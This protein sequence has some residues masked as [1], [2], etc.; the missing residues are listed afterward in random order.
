MELDFVSSY[1][2]SIIKSSCSCEGSNRS[3]S[4]ELVEGC[5]RC[6]DAEPSESGRQIK[7]KSIIYV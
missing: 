4:M 3:H 6:A 7:D 5:A 1:R 2:Q